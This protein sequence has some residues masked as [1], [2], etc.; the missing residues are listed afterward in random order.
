[1][2]SQRHAPLVEKADLPD[3]SA[4]DL[5]PPYL[6]L[7]R[8]PYE[9]DGETERRFLWTSHGIVDCPPLALVYGGL[10]PPFTVRLFNPYATASPVNSSFSTFADLGPFEEDGALSWKVES[11]PNLWLQAVVV[12]GLGLETTLSPLW[13]KEGALDVK[14]CRD[15]RSLTGYWSTDLFIYTILG[16]PAL[17]ILA[18]IFF[19]LHE[20]FEHLAVKG[21]FGEGVQE[22]VKRR[23]EARRKSY[24]AMYAGA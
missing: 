4:S 21:S 23:K 17:A 6:F 22:V 5:A 2:A 11:P 1:M 15:M 3:P 20:L 10:H 9:T 16:L 14:G 13:I 18:C 7:E 19:G 8:P 24:E 12:D